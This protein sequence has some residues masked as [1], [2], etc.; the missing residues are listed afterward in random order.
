MPVAGQAGWSAQRP[1]E[2]RT[3]E[4]DGREGDVEDV[5]HPVQAR[6]GRAFG[7][8][9]RDEVGVVRRALHR[10][11]RADPGRLHDRPA[12]VVVGGGGEERHGRDLGAVAAVVLWQQQGEAV[13]EGIA[14]GRIERPLLRRDAR[15]QAE[16]PAVAI[17]VGAVGRPGEDRE[18]VGECHSVSRVVRARSAQSLCMV[19]T[20]F[21]LRRR[22]AS[23]ASHPARASSR[24]PRR[25]RRAARRARGSGP[26]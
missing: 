9:E 19:L 23:T 1:V 17:G 24:R 18:V 3:R 13:L 20:C 16:A 22:S 5:L 4:Q 7:A 8:P 14:V 2:L 10:H 26:G 11:R 21:G 15:R 25:A 6:M 12:V